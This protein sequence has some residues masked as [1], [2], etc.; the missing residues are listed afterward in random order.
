MRKWFQKESLTAWM[1]MFPGLLLIGIFVFWPIIYSV[2]LSFTDY[3]VIS[4]TH[5][6][7]LKNFRRAFHDHDF[8]ISLWHS[9]VYIIIVPFIQIFAILMAVLM[10]SKLPGVKFFRTAYYLPVVTSM[11]AVA[12]I[13]GWLY[14]PNG[15]VNY[16]LM[17]TG[18]ISDK[19]GWL[20]SQKTALASIMFVTMWKGLGYYMMIYLA[21]LQAVPKD[22]YEAA[23]IDGATRLQQ[24]V[25]VTIPMLKPYVFFCTLISMMS[26]IRVFDEV[27]VLTNSSS[28]GGPGTATLTSSVYIYDRGFKQFDFGYASAMGLIVSAIILVFSIFIFR[29]NKKGG[30]NPY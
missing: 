26:A 11:V 2:P 13:W 27:F 24:V 6:I 15:I 7:G 9:M 30:V 8:L 19:I 16:V 18:I 22:L 5:Y 25:K 17:S 4:D 28:L 12:I 29:F 20:S 3:S 23:S 1:F 10:N 21:G 14:S